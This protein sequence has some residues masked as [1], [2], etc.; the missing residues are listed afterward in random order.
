MASSQLRIR[1]AVVGTQNFRRI[2]VDTS[3]EESAARLQLITVAAEKLEAAVPTDGTSNVRLYFPGGD[4]VDECSMLEKDDSV[5]LAFD[6]GAWREPGDEMAGGS[7]AAEVPPTAAEVPPRPPMPKATALLQPSIGSFMGSGTKR[8]F[9]NDDFGRRVEKA[10]PPQ[11]LSPE[12]LAATP[13]S[14][15]GACRKCGRTFSKAGPM[16]MHVASC[17]GPGSAAAAATATAATAATAAASAS[18][19]SAASAGSAAGSSDP[20]GSPDVADETAPPPTKRAK[21]RADGKAKQSGLHQGD[22]RN[23]NHTLY[24]RLE[25]VKKFREFERLQKLG[26]CA[27]PGLATSAHFNGLSTSNITRWKD[28]EERLRGELLHEH[29][30]MQPKRNHKGKLVPFSSKG[31]RR[32]SLHRGSL[33]PFA[34]AEVELHAEY[35]V[36][37]RG[38]G[39]DRKGGERVTGHWFKIRMKQL[40][41]KHYGDDAAAGFKGSKRWLA[42]FTRCFGISLRSKSNSKS[43]PVE[44][45]LPKIQRW[46]ARLRRRLKRGTQLDPKWGRWLPEDRIAGDQVGC[47]LRAGLQKTY[48]EKGTKRV[49]MAGSPAD[50]GK[51]FMTLN[52]LARATNGSAS[53]PRRGQPKIGIIF[54][55]SGQ[56]IS[57]AEKAGWHPDANVRFQKKAWADDEVCEAFAYKE[58]YEATAEARAAGRQS[59]CFFDNLSGQTT[60]EHLR[61]CKRAHCDRHLLPTGST[62]ELMLIDDGIGAAQKNRMAD[63][64]DAHLEKADNLQRWTA[65]PKE[66]GLKMWEKRVLMTHLAVRAWETL[67][68][69]SDGREPYDFEASARRI[70]MLMTIDGSDDDQ[71]QVQGL[72]EP[73]TFLDADGGSD[74]G[75]SVADEDEDEDADVD[76]EEGEG[77]DE[78][79]AEDGELD[80][81]EEEDDTDPLW[82]CGDAPEDAP[83]GFSYAVCP[84][85]ESEQDHH[86]LIGRKVLVA[87]ERTKSLDPGW[88]VGKIKLYGVSAACKKACP[89]A[90]FLVKYGKKE[91]GGA[92]EGDEA[93]ELTEANY[94][95]DEWW[96]LLEPSAA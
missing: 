80:D 5:W 30:T 15:A 17:K 23:P 18:A 20:F 70:G 42:G 48:D 95:R 76:E 63:E 73:Y 88:Y 65:G 47:N 41:R 49:W 44:V 96:L 22:V 79:E 13:A 40:V 34:A 2:R 66:G 39:A 83:E 37:R 33:R 64:L 29:A 43:E 92:L 72:T 31:A 24:F 87:H 81:S 36:R 58:L 3:A 91:T 35:R 14:T 19:T 12:E 78:E 71:I 86:K 21:P 32:L 93:L 82:S 89:S 90:N 53:K 57:V 84:T 46:H 8:E 45:R 74:G 16:A 52:M 9:V 94:G 11:F 27:A 75:E 50:D 38:N 54:R 77:E 26:R 51:R 56:K 68:C 4:P 55:G 69:G 25:V 59:G 28:A 10:G 62:G 6:G 7:T 1:V 85:L 61:N 60:A 67:C